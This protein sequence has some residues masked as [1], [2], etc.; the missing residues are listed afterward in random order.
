MLNIEV[1]VE[2]VLARVEAM[3][4]HVDAF[5]K[6]DM[7]QGLT[8]WQTE[9]MNRK[10]PETNTDEVSAA[11]QTSVSTPIFPRSRTYE[12]MHPHR[13]RPVAVRKPAL[14]SMP[15]LLKSTLR[16]PILRPEL[17]DKLYSRMV[18]LLDDKLK[19]Q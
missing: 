7:P 19:W 15:R 14:A 3:T 4:K 16:H 8:D 11:N 13:S 17:F 12:Q 6:T 5:G 10:Y 18:A 1:K 9:D 2:K